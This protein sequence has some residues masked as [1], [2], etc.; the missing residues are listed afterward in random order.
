M[1][2]SSEIPKGVCLG[3]ACVDLQTS[4]VEPWSLSGSNEAGAAIVEDRVIADCIQAGGCVA[5][6][7][8]NKQISLEMLV[9]WAGVKS[10]AEGTK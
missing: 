4:I 6:G 3:N 10:S 1:G 2:T 8:T 5:R 7:V 9:A